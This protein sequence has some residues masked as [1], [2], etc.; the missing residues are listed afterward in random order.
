MD[1]NIERKRFSNERNRKRNP[2]PRQIVLLKNVY[3][4]E[5]WEAEALNDV[6]RTKIIIDSFIFV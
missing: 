1:K 5:S 2:K 4:P 3:T 6:L